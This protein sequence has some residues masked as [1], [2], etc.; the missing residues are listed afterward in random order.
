[1][2]NRK[3]V[4]D[5]QNRLLNSVGEGEG[6]MFWENSIEKSILS[7]MKQ[8]QVLR[9]GALGRPRGIGWRGRWEGE[10]GRGT[11]VNPWL[12]HVNVWQKPLQYCKVIS[13]QLIKING[14]KYT[15][16]MIKMINF[17][18]YMV[19]HNKVYI[20]LSWF[21]KR[22]WKESDSLWCPNKW[23]NKWIYKEIKPVNPKGNQSWIFIGRTDAEAEA[24]IVWPPDAN[25]WLTRKD[26]NAGKDW[27]QEGEGDGRGWVGWRAL[28]TQC[29]WSEQTPGVGEGQ[30]SLACCSPWGRRELDTT[31][32]LNRSYKWINP[33]RVENILSQKYP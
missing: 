8:R 19:N 6:G 33:S 21:R 25:S 31:E 26:P 7:R 23:V 22:L 16:E 11:L 18:L 3:R 15:L 4:T 5:V 2:Q 30:G 14:K 17:I 20:G 27:R 13:L 1:M 9:A 29:S 24:P 28:L 12:I 32:Q 10:S